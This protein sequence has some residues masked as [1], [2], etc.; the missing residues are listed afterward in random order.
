MYTY[1]ADAD[2]RLKNNLGLMTSIKPVNQIIRT[3]TDY[4]IVNR[5]SLY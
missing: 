4:A 1:I 5:P 2:V 3:K